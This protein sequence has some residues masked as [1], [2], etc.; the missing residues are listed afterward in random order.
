MIIMIINHELIIN[1]KLYCHYW[2]FALS[3]SSL[4]Q[5]HNI[6]DYDNYDSSL[7]TGLSDIALLQLVAIW[8]SNYEDFWGETHYHHQR[9]YHQNQELWVGDPIKTIGNRR[10][11]TMGHHCIIVIVIDIFITDTICGTNQTQLFSQF[12]LIMYESEMFYK[13]PW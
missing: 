9:N 8:Q 3:W 12:T 4:Y 6:T 10:T 7:E 11:P 13:I 1:H 2:I 5:S